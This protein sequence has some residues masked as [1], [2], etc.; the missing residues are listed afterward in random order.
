MI[1]IGGPPVRVYPRI[2]YILQQGLMMG[3]ENLKKNKEAVFAEFNK[4]RKKSADIFEVDYNEDNYF[5]FFL[6]SIK[7]EP[8]KNLFKLMRSWPKVLK[9][10]IYGR[11]DHI[12][13]EDYFS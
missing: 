2:K 8:F 10:I 9:C 13:P 6:L 4:I 11:D 3:E 7:N 12:M 1:S 5:A